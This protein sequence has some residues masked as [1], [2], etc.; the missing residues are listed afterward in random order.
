MVA[1]DQNTTEVLNFL[2][3]QGQTV[4][5]NKIEISKQQVNYLEYIINP[6]SRQLSPDRKQAILDLSTPKTK[7]HLHTFWGIIGFCRIWS[8]RFGQCQTP[9]EITKGPDT[10]FWTG[11]QEKAFNNIK[12][13][14]TRAPAL[15][16]SN[17]KKTFILYVAEKQ[18]TALGVL[19]QKQVEVPQP[20]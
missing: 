16:L 11:E 14:L 17:L 13:A 9:Y 20:I 10:E 3:A 2:E 7:K 18:S 1:S 19:V 12:Q 4:S 8:L 5:Q 6:G 15:G